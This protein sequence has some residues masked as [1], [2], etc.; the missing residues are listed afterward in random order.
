M[1]DGHGSRAHASQ[2]DARLHLSSVIASCD[3]QLPSLPGRL[4]LLLHQLNGLLGLRLHLGNR[5]LQW[6]DDPSHLVDH[7]AIL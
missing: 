5:L 1:R 2:H 4:R 6:R 3:D 7:P